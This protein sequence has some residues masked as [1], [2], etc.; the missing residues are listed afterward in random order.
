MHRSSSTDDIF[1]LNT[2]SI[3]YIYITLLKTLWMNGVGRQTTL[4]VCTT[5]F[6]ALLQ[7][8]VQ[9]VLFLNIVDIGMVWRKIN[10]IWGI[11]DVQ[12]WQGLVHVSTSVMDSIWIC[13]CRYY[14]NL[15]LIMI[16]IYLVRLLLLLYIIHIY[17][18]FIFVSYL[19]CCGLLDTYTHAVS[20]VELQYYCHVAAILETRWQTFDVK[21]NVKMQLILYINQV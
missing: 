18:L 21:F 10:R 7:S 8:S 5:L 14:V 20:K 9:M 2:G 12:F 13:G 16:R 3:Y 17:I 4:V 11:I 6:L 19:K 15:V 1:W